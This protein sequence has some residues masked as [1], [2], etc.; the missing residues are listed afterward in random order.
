MIHVKTFAAKCTP[1]ALDY[2]DQHIND[3]V[4]ATRAAIVF[5]T[6]SFGAIEGKGGQ[7]EPQLFINIWYEA[8]DGEAGQEAET[9]AEVEAEA[10]SE[11]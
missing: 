2:M 10:E 9:E 4:K 7:R 5:A 3:W 1:Q 6:Q 11:L 8:T